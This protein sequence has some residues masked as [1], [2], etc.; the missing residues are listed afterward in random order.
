[1]GSPTLFNHEELY[2]YGYIIRIMVEAIHGAYTYI[3]AKASYLSKVNCVAAYSSVKY[4]CTVCGWQQI[5]CS[6]SMLLVAIISLLC[7]LL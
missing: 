5:Y 1:M 7:L 2:G 6:S 4:P 3:Y